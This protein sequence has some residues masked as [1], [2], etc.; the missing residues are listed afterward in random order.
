M[1]RA[2]E[3]VRAWH[4]EER[5]TWEQILEAYSAA[6]ARVARWTNAGLLAPGKEANLVV[7]EQD[8]AAG[9]PWRQRVSLTVVEGRVVFTDGSIGVW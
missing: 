5:L 2:E 1:E 6:P 7:V 3:G 9:A 4:P 8:P